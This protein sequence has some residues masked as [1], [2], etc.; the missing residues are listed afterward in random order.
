MPFSFELCCC[1]PLPCQVQPGDKPDEQIAMFQYTVYDQRTPLIDDKGNKT[2]KVQIE[3]SRF[4]QNPESQAWQFV[5]YKL[6]EV[7]ESLAR[8]A[9]LQAKDL[10]GAAAKQ[11]V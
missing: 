11:E 6:V 1:R 2:R 5:D 9:E 10:A 4:V 8:T 3:Q 7:P